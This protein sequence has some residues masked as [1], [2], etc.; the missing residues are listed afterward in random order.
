MSRI[1]TVLLALIVT[2]S[3]QLEVIY[4]R[5]PL[6]QKQSD[7]F[8]HGHR[9]GAVEGSTKSGKTHGGMAWL[10]EQAIK[11][12]PYPNLWWVA[13]VYKQARIAYDRYC[14]AIPATLR[15]A[16]DSKMTIELA[17]KRK[18]WF[19]S[20]EKP[21][22]MYG[23]DVAAAVVEEASRLRQESWHALRSTLTATRGP[24]RIIG[25]VKG[26]KNW[27][28]KQCRRAEAGA[29]GWGFSKIVSSDAVAGG[30]LDA[31]E[32]LD[33]QADLPEAVFKE[34]YLCEPND[35]GSNPFGLKAIAGA[36]RPMSSQP[37]K[38]WGVDLAKSVDWTAAIGLDRASQVSRFA[39]FQQPWPETT[40]EL[41][42]ITQRALVDST[43]VGDPIVD[44]LQKGRSNFQGFKFTSESKQRIMEGLAVAIQKGAKGEKG[45]VWYPDGV[46]V[47][48]L[49]A[50]EFQYTRTGVKYSAPEGMHDDT[51]CALALA[52][53]C[54][55]TAGKHA[56]GPA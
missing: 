32:I 37:P 51:V 47:S 28:Y 49:E 35:E 29:H 3:A 38:W 27:F 22:N 25:N 10:F 18:M 6:Y 20:G 41:S 7:A 23:D 16:N 17:N 13:P 14:R 34:L 21:D 2:M 54:R 26:K 5:P 19:V 44:T 1:V 30:V 8:F 56:W 48:E 46:I 39:R 15:T 36:I 11:E 55:R 53:E 31:Q 42:L 40:K 33:A 24:C 9:F 52:V 50:F 43:G 45:G 12:S 4:E